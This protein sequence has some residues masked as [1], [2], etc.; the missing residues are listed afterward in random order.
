MWFQ[1]RGTIEE[2][3]D[4]VYLLETQ[5]A[6]RDLPKRC[7]TGYEQVDEGHLGTAEKPR[8]YDRLRKPQAYEDMFTLQS[9]AEDGKM[10]PK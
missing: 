2:G 3:E 1:T 10:Q 9:L 7:C 4:W 8:A 5:D 6:I